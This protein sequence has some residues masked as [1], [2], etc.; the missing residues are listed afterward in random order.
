VIPG[1]KVLAA[2]LPDKRG[3]PN[4]DIEKQTGERLAALQALV[5]EQGAKLII[6]HYPAPGMDAGWRIVERVTAAKGIPFVSAVPSM[7]L[8]RFEDG[9]H[10][11]PE[12]TKEFTRLLGPALNAELARLSHGAGRSQPVAA[13]P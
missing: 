2:G 7:P 3:R 4:E 1:H 6:L 10:L 12:G 5:A 13:K 11:D 8:E 9:L